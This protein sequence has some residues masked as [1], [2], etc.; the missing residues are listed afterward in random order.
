MLEEKKKEEMKECT[1]KPNIEGN[2]VPKKKHEYFPKEKNHFDHLYYLGKFLMDNKKDKTKEDI[3]NE[4]L[5]NCSF[6]PD[7]TK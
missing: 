2:Y 7:I 4:E 1:F 6:K 5:K 3:E